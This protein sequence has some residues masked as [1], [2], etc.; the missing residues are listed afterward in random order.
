MAKDYNKEA[1]NYE[2]LMKKSFNKWYNNK[3]DT[4]REFFLALFEIDKK[5]P[6]YGDF[7]VY[8]RHFLK[9]KLN[10]ERAIIKLQKKK[11]YYNSYS[12]FT[13]L[14]LKLQEVKT[15][16]QLIKIINNCITKI[17]KIE[18]KLKRRK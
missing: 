16:Q 6:F 4:K 7:T 18:N 10:V 12:H 14:L 5:K 17:I 8:E 11:I 13:P 3:K 2:T 9:I 15:P 1:R